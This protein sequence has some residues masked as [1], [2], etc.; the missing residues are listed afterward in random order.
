MR[1]FMV[2]QMFFVLL[3]VYAGF[4]STASDIV[5]LLPEGHAKDT[6]QAAAS[7][8]SWFAFFSFVNAVAVG[9]VALVVGKYRYDII[10]LEAGA[11][12]KSEEPAVVPP[13]TTSV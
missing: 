8:D 12:E 5:D 6:A 2:S 13:A 7:S 9:F 11:T 3:V 1:S 10:P 4:S